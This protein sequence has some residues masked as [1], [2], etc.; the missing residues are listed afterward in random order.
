MTRLRVFLLIIVGAMALAGIF[1]G[2]G[3]NGRGES[4]AT[5][6][7]PPVAHDWI[8]GNSAVTWLRENGI[9]DRFAYEFC[10]AASSGSGITRCTKR[11]VG[12]LPAF[13]TYAALVRWVQ[14]GYLKPGSIA[15]LDIERWAASDGEGAT[16][17]SGNH[18]FCEAAKLSVRHRFRLIAAD[19]APAAAR[20][21]AWAVDLQDQVFV[22]QSRYRSKVLAGAAQVRAANPRTLILA[23]LGT[24]AGGWPRV[25]RQLLEAWAS[26]RADVYGFWLNLA[27]WPDGAG[28]AQAGCVRVGAAFLR[29]VD[30]RPAPVGRLLAPG[31]PGPSAGCGP[32]V[33]GLSVPRG[34]LAPSVP[35][36]APGTAHRRL[37]TEG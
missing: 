22:G 28:C 14:K 9:D 34:S 20:C 19:A 12:Q 23:G 31:A 25:P 17:A 15:M 3:L 11:S 2:T 30:G 18:Y 37:G 16:A 26:V 8:I 10:G 13:T 33:H 32:P 36:L 6:P 35:C 7:R 29:E 1:V 5:T 24:D 27:I 4:G 21:G